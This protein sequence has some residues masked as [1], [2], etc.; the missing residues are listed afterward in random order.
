MYLR[1]YVFVKA[2]RPIE[3]H[4]YPLAATAARRKRRRTPPLFHGC[5]TSIATSAPATSAASILLQIKHL[6]LLE[7]KRVDQTLTGKSAT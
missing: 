5:S 4:S 1:I 2:Y 7:V 6:R 3:A